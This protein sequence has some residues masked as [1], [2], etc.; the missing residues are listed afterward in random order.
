M[1]FQSASNYLIRWKAMNAIARIAS[2]VSIHIQLL[3]WMKTTRWH[4]LDTHE[5]GFN[6]HPIVTFDERLLLG[7]HWFYSS[8]QSTSNYYIGWKWYSQDNIWVEV[9]FNPHPIITLDERLKNCLLVKEPFCF[10]PHSTFKMNE[11]DG[12]TERKSVYGFQSAINF[13]LIE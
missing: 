10:N 6:P 2:E 1:R 8:F 11:N 9:C 3:Y 12:T 5:L 13:T 7:S 4:L